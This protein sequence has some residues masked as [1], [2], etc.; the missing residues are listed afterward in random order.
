MGDLGYKIFYQTIEEV[1][2]GDELFSSFGNRYWIHGLKNHLD[3]YKK[4][5]IK[6]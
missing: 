3:E 1:K 2:K 5:E 6:N 4:F